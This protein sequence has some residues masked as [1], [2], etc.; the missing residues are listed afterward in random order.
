MRYSTGGQEGREEVELD[1]DVMFT[2]TIILHKS[3]RDVNSKRIE[4]NI[5]VIYPENL[6]KVD[7]IL[8]KLKLQPSD[9]RWKI[10]HKGKYYPTIWRGKFTP[11]AALILSRYDDYQETE[12][13]DIMKCFLFEG[14]P[15]LLKNN[16]S[17]K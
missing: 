13:K 5:I 14:L 12:V 4:F 3:I 17:K 8:R 7:S 6:S 1:R 10:L 15:L 2:Y 9:S 11:K 16:K